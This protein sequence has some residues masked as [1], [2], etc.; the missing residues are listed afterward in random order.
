MLDQE[1]LDLV[2]VSTPPNARLELLR[3][4]ER[5]GVPAAVVEKPVA[6]QSEDYRA[7]REFAAESSL[8]VVVNHQLHFHPRRLALAN[9]VREG[10]IGAVL[11]VDASAG[12]NMAYQGTHM[13]EAVSAFL[14]DA[15]AVAVF[16][17]LSGGQGLEQNEAEHLAPDS[18]LAQVSFDSGATAFLRCGSNAPRVRQGG[19]S[20]Y[21]HKRF[22][23]VGDSGRVS[24]TM[25]SWRVVIGG[26]EQSGTIDF[27]A[28]DLLGQAAL[29]EAALRWASDDAEVHPLNLELALR[30]FNIV[31]GIYASALRR[32]IVQLPVDAPDQLIAS[33]REAL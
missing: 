11:L 19:E 25:W 1:E 26:L 29:T 13:L 33:L 4:I 20:V 30:D 7:L 15:R 31:L 22:M 6:I 32:E 9:I 5:S 23:V 27:H 3:D 12:G 21:Y 18:C 10:A 16:A 8:K 24:W 2:H 28:E 17:A 14:G